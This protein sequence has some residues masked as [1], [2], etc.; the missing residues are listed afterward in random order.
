MYIDK[1]YLH[2]SYLNISLGD[3]QISELKASLDKIKNIFKVIKIK[4][5]G[6]KKSKEI[7]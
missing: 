4:E 1:Q 2:E 5:I 7:L 6:L 3:A